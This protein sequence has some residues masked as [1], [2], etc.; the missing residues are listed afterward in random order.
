MAT[1]LR[2]L[3]KSIA[4]AFVGLVVSTLTLWT[5]ATGA[6]P[7]HEIGRIVAPTSAT[8]LIYSPAHNRL[9]VK[10]SSSAIVTIDL[11]A[12]NS[13]THLA[14]SNF[15]DMSISPSGRYVFAADYGGENIGYGTP[16]NQ[17]YVHR[18]DL[19]NS[20]WEAKTAYIAGNIQA[21]SDGQLILKSLDQWVTFTNNL[22]GAGAAVVP[23][24]TPSGSWGPAYY[25]TAY[26]G[27]FRYDVNT[28]RLLHGNAGLSSQEIQAFKIVGN[29]FSRQE[30]SGIYGSAQG[31][32]GTVALATDGSAFYYGE[33][34]V[35]ALDVTHNQRVFPEMIYAATGDIAFGN[36][37]YYNAHTG[38]LLGTLGF[39]TTRYGLS[40]TGNEFWA[41]DSSRNMLRH[42]TTARPARAATRRDFDFN[43]RSDITWANSSTGEKLMWLM[44]GGTILGG[45]I[46]LT[47]PNWSIAHYGD[48][49][50]D[51]TTDL[52]WRNSVT[53]EYVMWLMDGSAILSARTLLLDPNWSVIHVGDFN[54]DGMADLLWRNSASG[55]TV[56]W[57]MN[58]A[59]FI[60]GRTLFTNPTWVVTHVADFYADGTDDLLIHD[61]S[62]GQTSIMVLLALG[63]NLIPITIDPVWTA[64][65]VGD[66]N[67]D[68][69]ADIV[70]RNSAGAT[71]L[72]LMN[73]ALF[74]GGAGLLNDPNWQVAGVGD[75][76]GDG[77]DDLLWRNTSTG[78][79]AAWLMDGPTLVSGGALLGANWQIT[80]TGDFNGDGKA[81]I[82]FTNTSTGEKVM[83]LMNGLSP[84][85]G[86]LLSNDPNWSLLP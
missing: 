70:W 79:T 24:N 82:L 9:L 55:E 53:G 27:D 29:E 60:G 37:N 28:A 13:T 1:N 5:P 54:G 81:D 38:N 67:G 66:F 21:V 84:A 63:N 15:T 39:Q 23:I 11:G 35:D 40:P 48:F 30:G 73:G 31:Y 3:K 59:T 83:W 61:T 52:I 65:H 44:N 42:F 22:W 6:S 26:S 19:S 18:L 10:N 43:G 51:G 32:G 33:L 56:V 25:A 50:G 12:L 16:L 86:Y 80:R 74:G 76:N 8:E 45:G 46:V 77:K 2:N 20:I 47:D 41:Y 49:N 71:A 34:Q 69:K 72:W 68:G 4:N 58:G 75:L 85:S 64:T 62:N 36:G 7:Y 17:S 57:F 14:N 78:E